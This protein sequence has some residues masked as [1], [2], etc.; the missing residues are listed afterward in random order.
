MQ[1]ISANVVESSAFFLSSSFFNFSYI[2]QNWVNSSA[3]TVSNDIQSQ[4]I[5]T[6]YFQR[7]STIRGVTREP[8]LHIIEHKKGPVKPI[9]KLVHD[10]CISGVTQAAPTLYIQLSENDQL[11]QIKHVPVH[12]SKATTQS[13]LENLQ[14][15]YLGIYHSRQQFSVGTKTNKLFIYTLQTTELQL[16]DY[17]AV[18]WN[19][20]ATVQLHYSSSFDSP[21]TLWMTR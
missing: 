7:C 20:V 8:N 17:T 2:P 1:Q 10:Q 3:V 5:V 21:S 6:L 12:A 13:C 11:M 16:G 9:Y 18:L 15:K 14:R 19:C 4:S